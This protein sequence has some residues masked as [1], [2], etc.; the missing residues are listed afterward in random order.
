MEGTHPLS[1]VGSMDRIPTFCLFS[2]VG[3]LCAGW[4]NAGRGITRGGDWLFVVDRGIDRCW[5]LATPY[6]LQR[7]G[8]TKLAY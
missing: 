7:P 2:F 4:V 5:G 6:E 1:L 8:P 3:T